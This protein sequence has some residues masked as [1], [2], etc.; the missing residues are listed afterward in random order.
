MKKNIIIIFLSL[1]I[2][3]LLIT[4]FFNKNKNNF[5]IINEVE[6]IVYNYKILPIISSIEKNESNDNKDNWYV[7]LLNNSWIKKVSLKNNELRIDYL[8]NYTPEAFFCTYIYSK[9]K[10]K[11]LDIWK[12]YNDWDLFEEYWV[13]FSKW[14]LNKINNDYAKYCLYHLF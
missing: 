12:M 8:K 14:R 13:I 9:D 4:I 6:N 5:E 10:F 2:I 3:L 11:S 1:T 7:N